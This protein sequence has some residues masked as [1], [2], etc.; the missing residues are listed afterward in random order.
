MSMEA[1]TKG[2]GMTYG[3]ITDPE[4][5]RLRERIGNIVHPYRYHEAASKDAIRHFTD[6]IGDD[7]PLWRDETYGRK[8][9]HGDIIAPPCF[10]YSVHWPAGGGGLPGVHGYHSGNDWE[11]YKTIHL[12]DTITVQ[13]I[14]GDI[15]EKKRSNFAGRSVISYTD[16]IYRNQNSEIVAKSTGWSVRAE[17]QASK[18]KGKF[19][20]ISKYRYSPEELQAIEDAY[21][22]E[23][24][25]GST[26]RFWEDVNEGDEL[27]PVVKGPLN[28]TDLHAYIAGTLGGSAGGRGGAHKFGILYRRRHPAWAYTDPETGAVDIPEM[29]H[30]SDGMADEIGIPLAYDYGCQRPCWAGHLVTN[31]MGD[32]GFL[33]RLYV[34]L[35]SFNMLGDTTWCKGKVSR[36]YVEGEEHLVELEL[37]GENQRGEDNFTGSATVLLPYRGYKPLMAPR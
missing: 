37:K 11:F 30:A 14:P 36:K 12:D 24:I 29:V 34:R 1:E 18:E 6:G 21:D 20:H 9:R 26:P 23:E 3:K 8:T 17:R 4:L 13:V 28:L 19:A 32:D 22:R 16:S 5:A 27:V 35:T 10:L 2:K 33:K 15:V 7:N 31:W 25:R